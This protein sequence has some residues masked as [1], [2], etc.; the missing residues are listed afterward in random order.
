MAAHAGMGP[1]LGIP[2]ASMD[3]SVKAGAPAEAGYPERPGEPECTF[4]LRTGTCK[5][6]LG[7]KFH[8]PPDRRGAARQVRL[9][10]TTQQCPRAEM[11]GKSGAFGGGERAGSNNDGSSRLQA[12]R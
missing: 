1:S 3:M 6:G 11:Q 8:H 7:C 12:V 5:Y 4:Y 9:L 10:S 2:L